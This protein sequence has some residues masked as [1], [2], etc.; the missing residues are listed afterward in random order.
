MTRALCW[1]RRDLRL[2]DHAALHAATEH[3]ELVAVVFVFDSVILN[4]LN[5]RSDARVSFI[6]RSLLELDERLREQG[7][8]LI[9]RY[10]DPA[11]EIPRLAQ[12]FR[13]E[14][15]FCG[16]DIEPYAIAR[17]ATVSR[18]LSAF[19]CAFRPIKDHVIFWGNEIQT[20]SG[21]PFQVFTPFSRAWRAALR[22]DD[23][24]E[25]ISDFSRL[26]THASVSNLL[27]PINLAFAR[28]SETD[29]W[30]PAGSL[31]ASHRLATFLNCVDGYGDQR[32]FP[33][34]DA[35]SGLSAH[36][37]FGTISIRELVRAVISRE[38][39]GAEKWLSEL[40]CREFYHHI[41]YHFPHVVSGCFKSEFDAIHWPGNPAN[42]E[43]W[44]SG[45]TGYPI[46]DAAM[47]CFA[48]T[49]WM[50][51]RLRMIVASFLVKDLLLD[52]RLGEA[53]FAEHLLDFDL[54]SNNGGWQW[55]ASVGCDAQPYFRI[56]NPALQSAKFDPD[57]VFI[58]KWCPELAQFSNDRIHAPHEASPFEQLEAECEIGR[59]YPEPL[60]EHR[61][62]KEIAISLFNAVK[63]SR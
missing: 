36:L 38:T 24:A 20:Q 33:S 40:I 59:D 5:N 48:Q 60:V 25:R 51:N 3:A 62:Q 61:I 28:F 6:Y 9:L 55:A 2:H 45:H 8:A 15:V 43:L 11:I 54:A 30:I 18:E 34:L 41:L 26:A 63:N 17:D 23:Y 32:D 10:G 13:A 50:H 7:S 16:D 52:W 37:R 29:P 56:F 1:L 35:T 31:A 22:A 4:A 46:V 49:G 21:G 57:G 12:E 44:K 47:R 39:S 58:R 19:S 53:Y 14:A 27:K 42:F